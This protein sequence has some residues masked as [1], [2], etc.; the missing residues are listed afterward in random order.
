MNNFPAVASPR[1]TFVTYHFSTSRRL[2]EAVWDGLTVLLRG[3][4]LRLTSTA[5]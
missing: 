5:S 3:D 4:H 1:G 2:E